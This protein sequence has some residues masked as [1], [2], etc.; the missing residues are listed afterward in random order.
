MGLTLTPPLL[1]ITELKPS[2]FLIWISTVSKY[3]SLDTNLSHILTDF[4]LTLAFE[5]HLHNL[6]AVRSWE[7]YSTSLY[8]NFLISKMGK[9]IVINFQS[10][11]E[12]QMCWHIRRYQKVSDWHV[13]S[14]IIF[15][16]PKENLLK[17]LWS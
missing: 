8:L 13:E 6:L 17:S 1:F 5:T 12:N 4:W 15:A 2:Y 11:C 7:S 16:H 3:F 9:I 14:A 10:S